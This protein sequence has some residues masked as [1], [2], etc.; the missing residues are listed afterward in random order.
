MPLWEGRF[1]Q[2][3]HAQVRQ[4]GDSIAFDRRLGPADVRTN[5]TYAHGLAKAGVLTDE[6]C[7][8]LVCALQQVES[9]LA[10][11]HLEIGPDDEDVHAA[12]ESRLHELV[13]PI[14]GKLP[15]G[16]S[17]ND[18]VATDLRLYLLQEMGELQN[19]IGDLQS[20]L[21]D[22]ARQH[23][24]ALMPG[25]THGRQAQPILFSHW[26]LSYFWR[27]ER[28]RERLM[29]G[30]R[31][32]A[33]L[34]LGAGALAGNPFGVDREALA[35]DLGWRVAENSLDAVSDRDF[36]VD[37]LAS[38]ALL[39]VHLSQLAED[40]IVWG[41]HEFGFLEVGETYCTG[42]SLMP[43]KQNPDT[44]ELIR[45]KTGRII[46]H[47]TGFLVVLKGLTSGYSKDLQEDK[48]A[49][50]DTVDTLKLELPLVTG[51]VE[52]LKVNSDRMAAA[53]D[54]RLLATDLADYL[55]RKGVPFRQAHRLVGKTVRRAE[56]LGVP[57]PELSLG[58]YQ[59][60]SGEFAED[61]YAV[62]DFHRSVNARDVRG[63]TAPRA[64]KEQ[65]ARAEAALAAHSPSNPGLPWAS[66]QA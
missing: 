41:S 28:D 56:D 25:Y 15:T 53:L 2:R 21:L 24:D 37:F 6:E 61:L 23:L 48:E 3:P 36:V 9:E 65:I 29:D 45:G 62:F 4:F 51:I 35:A 46:G 17:R 60:I 58:E 50:F 33:M 13:G 40:L 55:V 54:A 26:L 44:L 19:A 22:R 49:L 5:I 1:S 16:R 32:T 47:L 12:V 34:P 7:H 42:S 43:Q 57:L 63:G 11:G 39:Q 27:L 20:A 14:A 59:T 52:T 18:Q 31:R 64:V 10:K 8:K 66:A 38:A 30:A